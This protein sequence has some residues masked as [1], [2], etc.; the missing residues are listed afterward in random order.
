MKTYISLNNLAIFMLG[1]FGLGFASSGGA[2][3]CETAALKGTY[4]LNQT[5]HFYPSNILFPG[6]TEETPGTCAGIAIANGKGT[7]TSFKG[8]CRAGNNSA[9][10]INTQGTYKVNSD[11]RGNVTL[12][13]PNTTIKLQYFLV[14]SPQFN[15]FYILDLN[16]GSN[17]IGTGKLAKP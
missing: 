10:M 15:E 2:Q 7:L 4:I 6:L 16:E 12:T 13:I 1:V 3:T 8:R 11:C 5:G 9:E 14:F 17:F